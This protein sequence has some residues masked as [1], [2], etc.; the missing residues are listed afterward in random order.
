MI[1]RK[2]DKNDALAGFVYNWVK[3]IGENCDRLYVICWQKSNGQDLPANIE[4][5]NL[6][7]N[8]LGKII[9]IKLKVLRLLNNIDGVFCHMN[10]EYTILAGSCVRLFG[11]GKKIVAWYTHKQVTW[12]RRLM[13]ML[14]HKI[15]TASAESFRDPKYPDKVEVVGHGINIDDFKNQ[16]CHLDI[17]ARSRLFNII[18]VGRISPTKD[19]ET[20]IKMIYEMKN[21]NI[22]LKIV[23]DVILHSQ[24]SYKRMLEQMV[25]K[26]DLVDQVEFTGWVAN[27]D[28]PKL[29]NQADLFINM[30]GTGS[31][32][33]VVLEA[34]ATETIVLT[35]NEAFA[36]ILPAELMVEKNNY[37]KLA[38]SVS[39]IMNMNL[40]ERVMLAKE[41]RKIVIDNHNLDNLAKKIVNE[42][43]TA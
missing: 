16:N 32:D 38:S 31:V 43:K 1:T 40:E 37:N 26:M 6:P 18:T 28:M 23:G 34:M 27:K 19:Y 3:K 15:I 12:R 7:N 22:K 42:Y 35:A 39:Q 10:P 29:Y 14:A 36:S 25:K 30:S 11:R 41:L 20:I 9:M 8:L 5:I 21:E 33:K 4:I 2:V 17:D 13:E 24:H